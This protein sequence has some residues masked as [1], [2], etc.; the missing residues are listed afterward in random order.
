MAKQEQFLNVVDR[1]EAERRFTAALRLEPLGAE[2]V[3]LD[4]ALGRVLASDVVSCHDVPSFDRSNYDGYAV[5]AADTYGATE[6]RPHCLRMAGATIRTGELP[7]RALTAGQA[8][9]IATGAVV[10]RGAD[11]V[12]MIEDTD[13]DGAA[14]QV[15]R[16]VN[17]GFGIT[18][19]GTDIARGETVLWRSERLT[20]RETGVLAAIGAS[21]VRVFKR[22]RVGI[23]ST[24][25]EIVSPDTNIRP[26][27]VFDSNAR[28]LADAVHELGGVPDIRGIVSDDPDP[29]RAALAAALHECDIVLLSGG[30]SKGAGDVS[31]RVVDELTRPGIVA[32]GVAL[33]PGKPVCLASHHGKPVA[34]LPGFP[35]SAI[36][37]FHEFIAPVIRRL[38]GAGQQESAAH[39]TAR[40]AVPVRSQIGRT[41]FY[42]VGLVTTRAGARRDGSLWAF[43]MG[44]GSGSVTTFSRAD[45]F[46]T[47]PR[48]DEMIDSGQAVDVHLLA[49]NVPIADLVVIGSHCVGLDYLLGLLQQHGFHTKFLAV[50]STAGLEAVRRGQCDLAG[51]HLL[52]PKTGTYNGPFVTKDLTLI[53]GYRRMQG[54]VYRKHDERFAGKT[55]AQAVQAA[56]EDA[57]CMMVNRNQ[58][59]GTRLLIDRLLDGARPPGHAVQP[60]SHNAV[61]AAVAQARADWG[62]AVQHVATQADLGFLPLTEEHYDFV[63]P[64]DRSNNPAIRALRE[65]LTDPRVQKQ[66]EQL[67]CRV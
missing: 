39:V 24:G 34:V 59:S 27:Q 48:H 63:A 38:A 17:P 15:R 62:V 45:G 42:L 12:V 44:K 10:P 11:A 31:Y 2:Q 22:P 56:K 14:V 20:S 13:D 41:E 9:G 57:T 5:Q 54:I 52:D 65:L 33:K 30:T 18:F 7:T 50:G 8:I 25:D 55:A 4:E 53:T 16:S 67:G 6:E 19:A 43:P 37:T 26:G 66:L 32:H 64:R 60:R 1:D 47:I 21:R 51:I 49:P 58:G 29:L 40:M 3:D 46:V 36:F 35:T 61:A 28:I 23:I